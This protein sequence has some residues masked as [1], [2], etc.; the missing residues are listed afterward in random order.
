[1]TVMPQKLAH[2]GAGVAGMT[3][4]R[5]DDLPN[6]RNEAEEADESGLHVTNDRVLHLGLTPIARDHHGEGAMEGVAGIGGAVV[7][8]SDLCWS[9]LGSTRTVGAW[10]T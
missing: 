8:S 2:P 7:S 3:A 4:V 9:R 1:M 5:I 6:P 10:G